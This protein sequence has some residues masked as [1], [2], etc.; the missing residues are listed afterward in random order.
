MYLWSA[1]AQ[2]SVIA[3]ASILLT[4]VSE[5]KRRQIEAMLDR[6]PSTTEDTVAS[7]RSELAWA[8]GFFGG[9]A[10]LGVR[11]RGAR[12]YGV[13]SISQASANGVPPV[14]VRFR[15][16]VANI[17]SITG[18]RDVPSPWSRLPQ[19]RWDVASFEGVQAVIAMLWRDLD[20]RSQARGRACLAALANRV[21]EAP[22]PREPS[23][24]STST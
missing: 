9:E 19:Y 12:R 11:R 20:R 1:K 3:A 2:E 13:L 4:H 18:P 7:R 15:T 10:Y 14:L 16:A 21:A 24:K 5:A 8:A 22:G 23:E 6:A 17:G